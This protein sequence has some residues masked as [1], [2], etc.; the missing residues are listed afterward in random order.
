MPVTVQDCH[1]R[2]MLASDVRRPAPLSPDHQAWFSDYESLYDHFSRSHFVCVHPS[3]QA[4]RFVV[5]SCVMLGLGFTPG[6]YFR[7]FE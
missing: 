7:L 1:H 2:P 4:K 6:V 5:F 3:C